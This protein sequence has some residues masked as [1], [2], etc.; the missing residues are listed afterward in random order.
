[1]KPSHDAT[2]LAH[3]QL[4]DLQQHRQEAGLA[5]L[6]PPRSPARNL[7]DKRNDSSPV[8]EPPPSPPLL[9]YRR[10]HSQQASAGATKRSH[11]A[12]RLAP[13]S[14]FLDEEEIDAF[15][16]LYLGASPE[17]AAEYQ[18][19]CVDNSGV[20]LQ[21]R[22]KRDKGK[23]KA[24]DQD[25]V[26]DLE[27]RA[28]PRTRPLVFAVASATTTSRTF[29][30]TPRVL[31]NA[32]VS[33]TS[34]SPAQSSAS[35]SRA[36]ASSSSSRSSAAAASSR[37]SV[38]SSSAASASR[39]AASR[40]A[41]RASI[42]NAATPGLLSSVQGA[43]S[44]AASAI[45]SREA[46]IASATST[47][48]T[49]SSTVASTSASS[50]VT[51]ASTPVSTSALPSASATS[52]SSGNNH[53]IRDIVV[54]SVVIPVVLLLLALFCFFCQRRRREPKTTRC[55]RRSAHLTLRMA[56]QEQEQERQA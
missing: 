40:I 39:S 20:S 55:N 6:S 1:M 43:F 9:K 45:S 52:S 16:C 26:H 7:L 53:R 31:P 48:S 11:G 28:E 12:S 4:A 5:A 46:S 17:D 37:A 29:L 10:V 41:S 32:A 33:T 49:P 56:Q 25:T 19:R 44:D 15:D 22:V 18:A 3:R 50:S 24:V 30:H 27:R 42:L 14:H 23:R 54:P 8:R 51:S 13:R 36:L 47:R 21:Q 34:L 35:R 2:L 38:S